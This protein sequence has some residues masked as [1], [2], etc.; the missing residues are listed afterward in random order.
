MGGRFARAALSFF[1]VVFHA[2]FRPFAL[3]WAAS[4]LRLTPNHF[5]GSIGVETVLD[6]SADCVRAGSDF[7]FRIT[8]PEKVEV[9][10]K[11]WFSFL[12]LFET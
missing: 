6:V 9:C 7:Y 5:A 3:M 12:A 11:L 8:N 1:S 10:W 2:A 4:S